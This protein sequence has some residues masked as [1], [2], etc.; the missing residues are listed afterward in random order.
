MVQDVL[1]QPVMLIL[2]EEAAREELRAESI[3]FP[4]CLS[5]F[6]GQY[7]RILKIPFKPP[8]FTYK[9]LLV[10]RHILFFIFLMSCAY[11]RRLRLAL[12]IC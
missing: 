3:N 2:N 5:G 10:Y 12:K 6:P 11:V 4:K 8:K 7:I 1:Q 9:D